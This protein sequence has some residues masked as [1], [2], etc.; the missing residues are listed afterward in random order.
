[1]VFPVPETLSPV[2]FAALVTWAI[3]AGV[4]FAIVGVLPLLL[5]K[6]HRAWVRA[7]LLL[8]CAYFAP[9]SSFFIWLV[10]AS[11]FVVAAA[12]VLTLRNPDSYRR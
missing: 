8:S 1:M 2:R 11:S 12:L 3:F 5:P 6:T 10:W 9:K 4:L 7:P